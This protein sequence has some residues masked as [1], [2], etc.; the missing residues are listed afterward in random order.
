MTRMMILLC[1][2]GVDPAACTPDRAV[3]QITGPAYENA[4]MCQA[5]RILFRHDAE[6]QGYARRI[7]RVADLACVNGAIA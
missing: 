1:V 7:Q 3:Q 5:H 4:E 6:V 2:M